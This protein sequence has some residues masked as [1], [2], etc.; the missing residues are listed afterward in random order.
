MKRLTLTLI[1]LF[2]AT[3]LFAGG[4]ECEMKNHSAKNV[5]LTGTLSRIG[6]GDE[7]KTVFR[8]ANSDQSYTVCHK[9]KAST[10]ELTGSVRVKGKVVDCGEGEGAEL[11]IE[12]AK[13]I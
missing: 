3:N 13:K 11:V 2:L 4:K 8:V 6:D 1:A 7:A 10:L 5:T 12:S 9:S